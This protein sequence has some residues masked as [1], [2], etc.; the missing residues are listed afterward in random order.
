MIGTV[1]WL[2]VF[3][4]ATLVGVVVVVFSWRT[5]RRGWRDLGAQTHDSLA[6]L[7]DAARVLDGL[8]TPAE[9]QRPTGAAA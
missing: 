6:Q 8:G 9:Y 7:A 1:P 5:L 3:V 2:L 4:G